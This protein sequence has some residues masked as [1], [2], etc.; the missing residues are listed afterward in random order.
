MRR[1]Q[2]FLRSRALEIVLM[3]G[4]FQFLVILPAANWLSR[5]PLISVL[6]GFALIAT[7][8]VV[9][10]WRE[11]S[12]GR[13]YPFIAD[14]EAFGVARKAI[15]FVISP[16]SFENSVIK[17]VLDH[18]PTAV[19]IGLLQTSGSVESGDEY[20]RRVL[21]MGKE[22][23]RETV[24]DETSIRFLH[25][26]TTTLLDTIMTRHRLARGEVVVDLT[27]GTKIM[28]VAVFMAADDAGVD[29]QYVH[30]EFHDGGRLGGTERGLLLRSSRLER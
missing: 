8:T 13:T 23:V 25:E 10:E 11:R 14:S 7:V 3:Y 24:G 9:I 4:A 28:S 12:R 17:A 2:A 20:E 26:S 30:S 16:G 18:Q 27:H 6:I 1:L 22:V 15:V 29:A 19:V 5:H 21:A